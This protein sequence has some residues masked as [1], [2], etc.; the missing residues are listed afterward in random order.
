MTLA[1]SRYSSPAAH[2]MDP[3]VGGGGLV[4]YLAARAYMVSRR[5]VGTR[6]RRRLKGDTEDPEVASDS[7]E[8]GESPLA[9]LGNENLV[10]N[11]G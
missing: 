10:R 4:S 6:R 8:R 11:M 1:R 7:G 3:S 9:V 2:I 5:S